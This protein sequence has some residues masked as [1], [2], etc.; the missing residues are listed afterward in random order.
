MRRAPR[1]AGAA[2]VFLAL[3][4][5][6]PES[7]L[8]VV[9]PFLGG[10]EAA[11]YELYLLAG[12]AHKRMGDYAKAVEV[13]DRAVSHYGVNAVLLNVLGDAHAGMGKWDQ[14]LAAY[15]RSLELSG[16]QPEIRKRVEALKKKRP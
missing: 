7:I 10:P 4:L 8:R 15:E 12:E 3:A 9:T 1:A 14:A 2:L 16:D 6:K 13:L 5:A 11:K